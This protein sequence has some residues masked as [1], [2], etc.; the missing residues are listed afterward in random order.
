MMSP[1][2]ISQHTAAMATALL[3]WRFNHMCVE[4]EEYDEDKA[5]GVKPPLAALCLNKSQI[6]RFGIVI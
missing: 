6:I 3:S 1:N 4:H 5:L 2:K